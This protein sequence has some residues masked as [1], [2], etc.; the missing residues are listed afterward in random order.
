MKFI[1]PSFWDKKKWTLLVICL[2][3]LTLFTEIYNFLRSLN[4]KKKYNIKTICIGNI[5]LGGTGK[6]PV[7]QYTA[8]LFK[9]KDKVILIKK[10]YKEHV[11][12]KKITRKKFPSFI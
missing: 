11:D 12:E 7:V 10:A 8:K 9:K 5:Y 2:Y 6:T 1:K 3:P 4:S